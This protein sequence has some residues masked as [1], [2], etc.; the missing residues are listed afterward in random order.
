MSTK[1]I[2]LNDVAHTK[3]KDYCKANGLR[4]SEWVAGLIHKA[5]DNLNS[6]EPQ[7]EVQTAPKKKPLVKLEESSQTDDSGV[8]VYSM[9]PFWADSK[10]PGDAEVAESDG[11]ES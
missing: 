3:A 7:P 8:P 1:V 6:P 4:M 2:H 9:P 11:E 10:P 5:I